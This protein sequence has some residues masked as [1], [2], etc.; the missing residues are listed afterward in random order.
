M[1]LLDDLLLL[2][3]R[4]LFGIFRQIHEL[5]ERELHDEASLQEKLLE[6][7]LRYET[8]EIGEE[9]YLQQAVDLEARLN[10]ARERA[11]RGDREGRG[12]RRQG[13]ARSPGPPREPDTGQ[14]VPSTPNGT[15]GE[16]GTGWQRSSARRA[17]RAP[18]EAS[19]TARGVASR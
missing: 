17:G 10:A 15:G 13:P 1:F 19:S 3:A 2:P 16:E 18:G 6:L 9:E 14:P 11:L 12:T 5:A 7:H 8:G 4:G